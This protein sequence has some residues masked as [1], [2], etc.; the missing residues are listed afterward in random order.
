[1]LVEEEEEEKEDEPIIALYIYDARYHAHPY[2]LLSTRG[3]ARI[4]S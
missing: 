3:V 4:E 2:I 1:M